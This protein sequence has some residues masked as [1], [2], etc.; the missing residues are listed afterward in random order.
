MIGLQQNLAPFI[1][2]QKDTSSHWHF[3]AVLLLVEF[4]APFSLAE[5]EWN[6]HAT[7]L[8]KESMHL[9]L[10]SDSLAVLCNAVT[11][12]ASIGCAATSGASC[13]NVSIG[14]A[15]I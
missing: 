5:T 9:F 7:G 4:H 3:S 13:G 10:Y 11:G 15:A 12:D 14:C 8:N 1:A 6:P 2:C